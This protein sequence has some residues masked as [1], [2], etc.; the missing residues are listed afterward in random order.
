LIFANGIGGFT[1]DGRE[2]IVDLPPGRH[3][4]APWVNVIAN[5]RLGTVVS[6]SGSAYTWYGNAQL[7]RL[8]PWSNDPVSDPSGEVMFIRD[9]STG[10]FFSPVSCPR[11]SATGYACRHGYGYSIF[12]HTEDGLESVLTTY[13]AIGAPVKFFALKIKNLTA[14]S[15]S[16]SV[17]A[18]VDLVL[19]DL[20]SGRLC[21][22]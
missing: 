19:G 5:G 4:P 20:R 17:F 22:S 11:A 15:R 9:E 8:T 7:F 12:E 1:R 6:E 14:R 2:Y 18:A 3:T 13:V 10:R 16:V 21:T